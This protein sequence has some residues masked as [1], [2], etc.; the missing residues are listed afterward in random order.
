MPF[1]LLYL[2]SLCFSRD[3]SYATNFSKDVIPVGL[4]KIGPCEKPVGP[5]DAWRFTLGISWGIAWRGGE[6]P[7]GIGDKGGSPGLTLRR[8][9]L[10]PTGPVG[11]CVFVVVGTA[12]L[13]TEAVESVKS[14]FCSNPSE[15][16]MKN[17]TSTIRRAKIIQTL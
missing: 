3:R 14:T 13:G 2:C 16:D 8:L 12:E 4:D 17:K 15:R 11:F 9:L 1:F 5:C 6:I 7:I 10:F